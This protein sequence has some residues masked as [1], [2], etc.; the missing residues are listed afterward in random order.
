MVSKIFRTL[1]ICC[2]L[3]AL[4]SWISNFKLSCKNIYQYL[5]YKKSEQLLLWLARNSLDK[6][7]EFFFM[8]VGQP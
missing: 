8:P 2:S 7:L 4:E 3:E 5:S 6:N 1:R